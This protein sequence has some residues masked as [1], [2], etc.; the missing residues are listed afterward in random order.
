MKEKHAQLQDVAIGWLYGVGCSIFAKEVPT[1]NGVADAL[2]VKTRN[3][4]DDVYYIE[5]K[6]SRS[7]LICKKQKVVYADATGTIEKIA[8]PGHA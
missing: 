1:Q 7:D 6:V 4:K 8:P 5:A 2:G 3:G